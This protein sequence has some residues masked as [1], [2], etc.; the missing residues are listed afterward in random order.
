[1]ADMDLDFS[2]IKNINI[3]QGQVKYITDKVD[4]STRVLWKRP[5]EYP[6]IGFCLKSTFKISTGT[7]YHIFN[8]PLYLADRAGR[9]KILGVPTGSINTDGSR[10]VYYRNPVVMLPT[11]DDEIDK[12]NYGSSFTWIK[13]GLEQNGLSFIGYHVN[14]ES[15]A[16]TFPIGGNSH[17]EHIISLTDTNGTA[18]KIKLYAIPNDASLL[19]QTWCIGMITQV[20]PYGEWEYRMKQHDTDVIVDMGTSLMSL[21]ATLLAK[22][23]LSVRSDFNEYKSKY[24]TATGGEYPKSIYPY[25]V[26]VVKVFIRHSWNNTGYSEMYFAFK[27]K[28]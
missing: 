16:N 7:K 26:G 25:L 24:D 18:N 8:L 15:V 27:I 6:V 28:R 11:E 12:N 14:S 23:I 1:M 17:C 5:F 4:G 13:S 19:D 21:E 22:K 20:A 3:P 9:T 2:Q 10:N